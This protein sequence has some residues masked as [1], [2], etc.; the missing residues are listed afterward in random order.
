MPHPHTAVKRWQV[1]TSDFTLNASCLLCQASIGACVDVGC[2]AT[3]W[4]ITVMI[5]DEVTESVLEC[6]QLC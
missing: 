1:L 3:R 2:C 4:I 5:A 6:S